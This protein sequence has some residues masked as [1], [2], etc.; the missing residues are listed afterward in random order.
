[1][2][3]RI[4]ARRGTR[5]A[6]GVEVWGATTRRAAR[7]EGNQRNRGGRSARAEEVDLD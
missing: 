6:M 1:V 3:S 7:W 5:D 4:D 2:A